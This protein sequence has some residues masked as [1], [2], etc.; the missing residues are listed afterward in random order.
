MVS[1][2][3]TN[4]KPNN[5]S[6][7]TSESITAVAREFVRQY[8]TILNKNP[9]LMHRF[10]SGD[11]YFVNG[12]LDRPGEVS[13]AVY[14]QENINK[15]ILDLN[16]KDCHAK[17]IQVDAMETIGKGVV[18]QL[19]GEFSN[20]GQPMRKFLQTFVLAPQSPTKFYVKNDIFR[21]QDDI[22]VDDDDYTDAEK[23]STDGG[24]DKSEVPL[25]KPI[26]REETI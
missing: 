22:F 18:I 25:L 3:E 5:N 9:N 21:Y 23:A 1:G 20:D 7:P 4:N 2:M 15:K 26:D 10:Y 16:F 11:S 8:Y 6:N 19:S 13:V 17:I 12:A 24:L 14:G